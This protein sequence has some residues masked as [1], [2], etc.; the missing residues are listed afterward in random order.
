MKKLYETPLLE[1]EKFSVANSVLTASSGWEDGNTDLEGD[2][3]F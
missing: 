3:E 2:G 1:I